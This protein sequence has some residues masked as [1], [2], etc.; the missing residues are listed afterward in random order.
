MHRRRPTGN[1]LTLIRRF[2]EW[3]D[4]HWHRL[5]ACAEKNADAATDVDLLLIDTLRAVARVYSERDMDAELLLRYTMRCLRN[6]ARRAHLG[7]RRR[8]EAETG[9]GESESLRHREPPAL[10]ATVLDLLQQ[11]P[12]PYGT[13]VKMRLWDELGFEDIAQRIGLGARTARRYYEAAINMLRKRK[14]RYEG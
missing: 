14:E 8:S 7:N 5:Y 6:A 3:V 10:Q 9:F 4:A 13:I 2:D 11:L 12:E 1:A